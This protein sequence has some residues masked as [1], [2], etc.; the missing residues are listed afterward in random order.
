M[1]DSRA[2]ARRQTFAAVIALLLAGSMW[3]YVQHVLIE[4]QES[5]AATHDIPRGNLSDLYPRWLGARELLLH[6]RNPYR[7]E[8][9][10]EIQ[11]GYYGRALDPE[12]RHD[13]EDQQGFAYPVYVVFLLAPTIRLP[14]WM[15]QSGARWFFAILTAATV[16]L[17][18][19]TLR[20]RPPA[21]VIAILIILLVGSFQAIQGIKLQQ[22]TLLVS[23]LIAAV[24]TLLVDDQPT[25][26][27][28]LLALAT[29][30]P[31]LALPLSAWLLVWAGSNWR[32][33]KNFVFGFVGTT[34]ALVAGG[35]LV[36]P[37]WIGQFCQAILAYRRYNNGAASILELLFGPP[38]GKVLTVAIGLFLAVVCWR[39]R[40]A[41]NHDAAYG[42]TLA[43]I[44]AA[45]VVIIPK[46][47]PYNQ[48]LLIAPV[49]LIVRHLRLLWRRG[50]LLRA[51]LVV[52]ACLVFWPWLATVAIT[53][54]S[55]FLPSS[56]LQ[57][58]WAA[59]IY[60]SLLIPLAVF[61]LVAFV[62]KELPAPES[63]RLGR[64]VSAP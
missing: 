23:G 37:G 54:V 41:S 53:G 36:L 11:I 26:A 2:L 43:L 22:L 62:G 10:R 18:L 33:R 47:A 34:M 14:F 48:V 57:N 6:H 24:A 12:R 44:L 61:V 50:P 4:H 63:S 51:A 52:A 19:R 27:G 60:D 30:K 38:W 7:P 20:W 42:W 64:Q 28:V 5:D 1:F 32:S 39:V 56:E 17:W 3:F 45:T 16:P 31:Q 29:I 15:V 46:A 9:T 58:A 35:E 25:L 59:P 21:S 8:I 40:H 55:P 13:P 49:L